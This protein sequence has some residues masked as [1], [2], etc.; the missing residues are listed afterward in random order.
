MTQL[1]EFNETAERLNK[2]LSERRSGYNGHISHLVAELLEEANKEVEGFGVEGTLDEEHGVDIQYVN[3][4]DTY[5]LTILYDGNE[6]KFTASTW[7][8]ILEKQEREYEQH[9]TEKAEQ[10]QDLETKTEAVESTEQPPKPAKSIL[11]ELDW[12]KL[13]SKTE[14]FR[15]EFTKKIIALM[16]QGETFWQQPWKCPGGSLPYNASS[17]KRY[18][19]VNVAYLMVSA[20]KNGFTDPRWMTYK[21]ARE[22]GCHVKSGEHGTKIEFYTEYDPS[23]TKK[24]AE[25]LDKKIQEMIDEGAS[26]EEIE[27]AMK[28]QKTLIVK[29]YTVFNASQI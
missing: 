15:Q 2:E 13:R 21:Q 26:Q 20:D 17:G 28:D 6:G 10:P 12:P 1:R 24:G 23:K 5:N 27:K 4:G 7:G 9:E 14:E 19:G 8:D 16:E 29:T 3:M 11:D 25:V 18:N 22:A